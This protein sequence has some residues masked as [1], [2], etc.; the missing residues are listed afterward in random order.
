VVGK[1]FDLDDVASAIEHIGTH[2]ARG[3]LALSV[4]APVP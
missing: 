3:K 1:E 2:R 4:S